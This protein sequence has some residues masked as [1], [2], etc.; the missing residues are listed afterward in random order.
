MCPVDEIDNGAG[1]CRSCDSILRFSTK[2]GDTC[3]CTVVTNGLPEIENGGTCAI[4]CPN[5]VPG[6][7][8]IPGSYFGC[9]C[10][11]GQRLDSSGL[12]GSGPTGIKCVPRC[13]LILPGSSLDGNG[14][15]CVCPNGDTCTDNCDSFLTGSTLVESTCTCPGDLVDNGASACVPDCATILIGSSLDGGTCTCPG[16]EVDDGAGVCRPCD[17]ILRFSTKVGGACVCTDFYGLPEIENGGTCAIDCPYAIPGSSNIPGEFFCKCPPDQI[18]DGSG[19]PRSDPFGFK[20]VPDCATIL[21]GSSLIGGTCTCPANRI[22][23]GAGACTQRITAP[24]PRNDRD[25][26]RRSSGG[27][28]GGGGLDFLAAIA[29]AA[30]LARQEIIDDFWAN[31]SEILELLASAGQLNP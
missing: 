8:N 23:N 15:T 25:R 22:D 24:A 3:Q 19:L 28:G 10:P 7:S 29:A 27:G 9:D 11:P 4:D 14:E 20:C 6:S 17:S 16:D 26:D 18:F 31:L 1:A 21:I 2:V 30:A 13:N 5:A 12:P